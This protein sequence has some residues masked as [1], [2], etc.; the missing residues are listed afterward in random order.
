MVPF[1]GRSV[2][3]MI[4]SCLLLSSIGPLVGADGGGGDDCVRAYPDLLEYEVSYNAPNKPTLLTFTQYEEK[5]L[6]AACMIPAFYNRKMS[7]PLV[8]DDSTGD[9]DGN[10]PSDF[11]EVDLLTYGTTPAA[12]TA[13]MAKLFWN[14]SDIVI[15]VDD[16]QW[17]L[18]AVPIASQLVAPMVIEPTATLFQQMGFELVI[19]VGPDLDDYEV[20][21]S[22]PGDVKVINLED[23]EDVWSF[24]LDV[25][26]MTGKKVDYLAVA[27]HMDIDTEEDIRMYGIS[28]SAGLL[29]AYRGALIQVD[30]YTAPRDLVNTIAS[31]SDNDTDNRIAFDALIPYCHAVKDACY[32]AQSFMIDRGHTPKYLGLVGGP[33]S[34]PEYVLDA[35]VYYKWWSHETHFIPSA[36]AYANHSDTKPVRE[37]VREDSA[38]GRIIGDNVLDSSL[39]LFRTFFYREFLD[40][41]D[42]DPGFDWWNNTFLL[43]GHRLNQ[44]QI[45]GPPA[46]PDEPYYPGEQIMGVWNNNSMNVRYEVPKNET[47]PSDTNLSVPSLMELSVNQSITQIIAHGN[48]SYIWFEAGVD[49]DTGDRRKPQFTGAQIRELGPTVPV[50][51]NNIACNTGRFSLDLNL[52]ETL[53]ASFVHIG[54]VAYHAPAT[55]QAICFRPDAPYG[56]GSDVVI[57]FWDTVLSENVGL[58]TAISRAKWEAYENW[59]NASSLDEEADTS[60]FRLFGDPALEPYKADVDYDDEVHMNVKLA[61]NKDPARLKPFETLTITPAVTDL[62][63]DASVKVATY[64]WTF[65]G[66]TYTTSNTTFTMPKAKGEYEIKLEILAT[67]YEPYTAVYQLQVGQKTGSGGDDDDDGEAEG[68][69][70][71]F[72]TAIMAGVIIFVVLIALGQKTKAPAPQKKKPKGKAAPTSKKPVKKA[73]KPKKEAPDKE[74]PKDEA[75]DEEIGDT[76]E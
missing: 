24:Q 37:Y 19:T 54:A 56:P 51:I 67:G 40:G 58:G 62:V 74:P 38:P 63:S 45:G 69:P 21:A 10:I 17:A 52:D 15:I 29:G 4:I 42:Y 71:K 70:A 36:A 6:A 49:P 30:N 8:F 39:L 3:L 47:D 31:A 44:R 65:E 48:P 11:K 7:T 57:S 25:F 22:Y 5:Y 2:V 18:M 33:F 35:H 60:T 55:G 27:N 12:Q 66:N 50:I 32:E 28:L 26:R 72:G 59:E 53:P 61:I 16:Y 13:A 34:L 64:K 73:T 43:D 9:N 46:S 20:P 1:L 14:S 41:G 23:K 75:D 76:R 68:D